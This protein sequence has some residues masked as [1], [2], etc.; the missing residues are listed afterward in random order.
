MVLPP[1][2]PTHYVDTFIVIAFEKSV[3][4]MLETEMPKIKTWWWHTPDKLME[5][6]WA[7]ANHVPLKVFPWDKKISDGGG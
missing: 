4:E 5:I 1:T 7:A 2:G 3:S 6:E